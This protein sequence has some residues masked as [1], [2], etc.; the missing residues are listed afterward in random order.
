[1]HLGLPRRATCGRADG[2]FERS[3]TMRIKTHVKAGPAILND[4]P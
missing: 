1:M 3:G 4:N 2:L